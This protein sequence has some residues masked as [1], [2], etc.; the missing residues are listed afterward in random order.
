M[1]SI[2]PAP[3]KHDGTNADW[4]PTA[5]F[6]ETYDRTTKAI[7]P[8]MGAILDSF[9]GSFLL[10]IQ[11][12]KTENNEEYRRSR[13]LDIGCGPGSFTLHFLLPR[14]PAWCGKL[15]AVDY[16]APMLEFAR[17]QRADPKI[18]YRNLDLMVDADVA[19]FVAE[20]GHFDMV[21]SFLVLHWVSDQHHAV[22]NIAEL[23][24]P[25]GE[26]FLVFAQTLV[27]FDIYVALMESPRWKK[28]S[29]VLTPFIPATHYMDVK[30][31]RLHAASLVSAANLVLL[32]GEVLL[33]TADMQISVEEAAD[34]YTKRNHFHGMLKED[35]K[36]ELW[37]FTY[38]FVNRLSKQDSGRRLREHHIFVIH[39]YKPR[40]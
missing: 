39:A 25:G 10:N 11:P 3:L 40:R 33:T 22:R 34:F 23:T 32:A 29:D 15:V 13:C 20:Q 9:K 19:R 16:A 6:A 37:K 12:P 17:N 26:C 36:Q 5:K 24:E 21:F 31:M 18:E 7:M 30:S 14:L 2:H 4:V 35:E 38:D 8:A 27:L 28:Y 1:S